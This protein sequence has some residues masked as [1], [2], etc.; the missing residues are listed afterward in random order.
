MVPHQ[1]HEGL[2]ILQYVDDTIWFMELDIE[3][4]ENLKMILCAFEQV[5]GLN[6]NF[7]KSEIICF[8]RAKETEQQYSS[9]FGCQ[10]GDYP[11]KYL[12]IPMHYRRL[13]NS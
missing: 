8:G 13:T 5:S 7:H 6:I 3:K 12:G 1:V 11:F 9:L 4:D 2:S 10:T